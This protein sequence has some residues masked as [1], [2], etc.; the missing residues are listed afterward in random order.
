MSVRIRLAK[1][2]EVP[3]LQ[4]LIRKNYSQLWSHRARRE[5]E[6]MWE[7][8]VIRPTYVVAEDKEIVGFAGYIQSWMDYGVFQLFWVN[9]H[10]SHQHRGIGKQL[11]ETL[12]S[13]I[14]GHKEAELVQLTVSQNNIPFYKKLGFKVL[15]PFGTQGDYLM[16]KDLTHET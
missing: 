11:V 6:A 10:P 5:I 7:D 14:K 13:F 15:T 8:S 9:V 2:K 16:T 1:K 3:Q 4:E 12:L